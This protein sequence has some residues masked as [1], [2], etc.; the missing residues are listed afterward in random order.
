MSYA[1]PFTQ[2][3]Y[4]DL[5]ERVRRLEEKID[6]MKEDKGMKNKKEDDEENDPPYG[7]DAWWE[8]SDKEAY[9]AVKRGEYIQFESAE[10]MNA[11]FKKIIKEKN[12]NK[13][14]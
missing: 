9:E 1:M 4:Q 8:K 10:E 14:E 3:D 2:S 7:S 12:E 6:G 5:E 11:Y 13:I